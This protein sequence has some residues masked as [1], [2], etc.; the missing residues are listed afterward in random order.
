MDDPESGGRFGERLDTKEVKKE[1]EDSWASFARD[2]E[3][4]NRAR[5]SPSLAA[6]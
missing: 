5:A 1:V 2:S 4:V 6:R 3:S